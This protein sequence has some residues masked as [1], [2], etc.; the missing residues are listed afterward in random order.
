MSSKRGQDDGNDQSGEQR[1]DGDPGEDK[2][3]RLPRD[4]LGPRE[5]LVPFGPSADR[6]SPE[7]SES[8][9]PS[10]ER[11]APGDASARPSLEEV[12]SPPPDPVSPDD[13]WGERSAALQGPL[14][15]ADREAVVD[16]ESGPTMRQRRAPV[17]AAAAA[18]VV[19][20]AILTLSLL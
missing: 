6:H 2:V 9:P 12:P 4:W 5:D 10:G 20:I 11:D 18:A 16:D 8:E 7:P 17:L 14:D 13:F 1:P 3:I 15:E 19:A